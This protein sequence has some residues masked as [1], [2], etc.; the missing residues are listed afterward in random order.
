MTTTAG[1]PGRT[2]LNL[3]KHTLLD[4]AKI[5]VQHSDSYEQ[6]PKYVPESNQFEEEP[7]Q[8]PLAS[9]NNVLEPDSAVVITTK[10]QKSPFKLHNPLFENPEKETDDET[11]AEELGFSER[12]YERA[13]RFLDSHNVIQIMPNEETRQKNFLKVV[14]KHSSLEPDAVSSP[15]YVGSPT[16]SK[17]GHSSLIARRT[18]SPQLGSTPLDLNSSPLNLNKCLSVPLK[19]SR[20][21]PDCRRGSEDLENKEDDK[22]QIHLFKLKNDEPQTAALSRKE[23]RN[24]EIRNSLQML[25]IYAK[26]PSSSPDGKITE[27]NSPFTP[28]NNPQF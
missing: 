22:L 6:S 15:L 19:A 23:G 27:E 17:I 11:S 26:K 4:V 9:E 10:R 7:S 1:N 21:G 12:L 2:L 28:S 8:G 18:N 14:S 20:F 5:K 16:L 13:D 3:T 25:R 24:L